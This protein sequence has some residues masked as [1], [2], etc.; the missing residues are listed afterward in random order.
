MSR[1]AGPARAARGAPRPWA[2]ACGRGRWLG[3]ARHRVDHGPCRSS[4]APLSVQTRDSAPPN[5]GR[6]V[7]ICIIFLAQLSLTGA[8]TPGVSQGGAPCVSD[9]DCSLGGVCNA[10]AA[11]SCDQWWTGPKCDLL[12]LA[13]AEAGAGLQLPNYFSWGG[14]ALKEPDA[15]VYHLFCSF[16][17]RHATLGEW[18]TKSSIWRATSSKPQGP[19][20]LAELVAALSR[21]RRQ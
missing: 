13:P 1:A 4:P 19:F 18:T 17:C 3:T 16:M 15:E 9:Y 10:S 8:Q 14:H 12:N 7:C 21:A 2:G 5:P 6:F 20:Q 11:C